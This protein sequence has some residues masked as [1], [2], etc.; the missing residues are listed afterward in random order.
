MNITICPC[1]L[2]GTVTAI[3]SKSQA[4][5]FLICAAFSDK[6]TYLQC[7]ET[8]QDIEATVNCLRALGCDIQHTTQGYYIEPI[9]SIPAYAEMNCCESGSTLR[10]ML[11]IVCAL[12]I[13]ATIHMSG[14]LPQRPLS[15][16]WEELIRM[17]CELTRPT[18]SSIRTIGKLRAGSYSIP[19]NISSQFISGLLFALSLL[20]G[21]NTLTIT[22]EIESAPYIKMTQHALSVFGV[23]TDN[24]RLGRSFPFHSPGNITIEGD[25]SNGAF[26][27]AAAAL[28]NNINVQGL[29]EHSL[30]GDRAITDILK[31]AQ[32]RQR[33]SAANIP[34]LVP[35]LS[36]FFAVNGGAEFTDIDRLRLKESDRV[37]AVIQMLNA[38]GIQ[39][40]TDD[41]TLRVSGGV[42]KGGTVNSFTDHRIAMSAAIAATVAR[43]SVTILGAEC[44]A[45]SYPT[46]WKEYRRLGGRYE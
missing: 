17:G 35:I 34:D 25:W 14:R 28:G 27:F 11:P 21:D 33:I 3:P 40:E 36:V 20:D 37:E 29:D 22:G 44:V 15:P 16:L 2:E 6:A 41:H 12:G 24:F 13:D 45:K 43:E 23:K 7:R 38:L 30:Q 4:H 10:F 39:A 8:N 9:T 5:R 18:P 42:F 26:F 46:F 19:G 32:P 1:K 31:Q